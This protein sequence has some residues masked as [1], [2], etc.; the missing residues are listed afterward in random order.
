M[1]VD[2]LDEWQTDAA[3]AAE[4]EVAVAGRT[5]DG[6]GLADDSAQ[7][8]PRAAAHAEDFGAAVGEECG[9]VGA[10]VADGGFLAA[11]QVDD[12]LERLRDRRWTGKACTGNAAGKQ[13]DASGD[14][15]RK[16]SWRKNARRVRRLP[17]ERGSDTPFCIRIGRAAS[18]VARIPGLAVQ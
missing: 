18:K 17:S 6:G 3:H 15:H 12:G 2:L 11:W 10:H 4:D 5:D 13:H 14:G 9:T 16:P 8:L 7:R 1:D